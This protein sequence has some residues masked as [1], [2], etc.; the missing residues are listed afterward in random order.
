MRSVITLVLLAVGLVAASVGGASA[1]DRPAR[2]HVVE[3][4]DTIIIYGRQQQPGAQY[5]LTRGRGATEV[6]DLRA[7]F[8]REV[9]RSV[10]GGPF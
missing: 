2:G 6:R 7:T 4:G 10:D 8:V 1:Q 9:V 3:L 5:V